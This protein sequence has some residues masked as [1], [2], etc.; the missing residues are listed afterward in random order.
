MDQIKTGNYIAGL[1]KEKNMTQ[2]ELAER[3]NVS[4]KT[5]SKKEPCRENPYL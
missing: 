5:I 1:R 4:D 3:I 2:R